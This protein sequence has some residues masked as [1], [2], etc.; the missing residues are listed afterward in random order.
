MKDLVDSLAARFNV[1][2]VHL[3]SAQAVRQYRNNLVHE[4]SEGSDPVAL[5]V[6]RRDLCRFFSYMP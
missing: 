1:G 6:V 4:G 3:S 2:P 5:N